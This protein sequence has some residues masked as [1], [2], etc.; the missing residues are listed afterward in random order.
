MPRLIVPT[1]APGTVDNWSLSASASSSW[2]AVRYG[3]GDD[4][5]IYTATAGITS[6]FYCGSGWAPVG[7]R[8]TA[9]TLHYRMRV[10]AATTA[11][12]NAIITQNSVQH[13]VGA[14]VVLTN[15]TWQDGEIRVREDWT[16]GVR[17]TLAEVGALG[18]GLSMAVAPGAGNI[19]VSQ[20]WLEVEYIDSMSCYDP[21]DGALPDAI[22]GP[23]NWI[24]LGTAPTVISPDNYLVITD[25]STTASKAYIHALP[26]MSQ[27]FTPEYISE[28]E[29]RFTLT[30]L[31][32]TPD[33]YLA[34]IFI[35]LGSRASVAVG[36]AKIGGNYY[37]TYTDPNFSSFPPTYTKTEMFPYNGEDVH[38]RIVTDRDSTPETYGHTQVFVNYSET[39]LLDIETAELVKMVVVAPLFLVNTNTFS[40]AVFAIDYMAW[41]HYKKRGNTFRH[42]ND[43]NFGDNVVSSESADTEI[44]RKI[45]I[46]PPGV[47]AGQSRNACVLDV[48]DPPALC[49]IFQHEQLL[50]SAPTTYKIDI[51]YKMDIA[52][53]EAELVVQRSSDLWY[54]DEAGS[55]WQSTFQAV[56][57]PNQ[58]TRTRLAAMTGINVVSVD[59]DEIIV[60][61]RRKTAVL[62]AYKILIYRVHLV[63]E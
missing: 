9:V 3:S 32:T 31:S 44:V 1:S 33:S 15:T 46:S 56:T 21:F 45:T 39:P 8:I 12:V 23:L 2:E 17:F 19:E 51:D 14:P 25:A 50:E 10:S 35:I 36:A 61:V 48:L 42:W 37:L 60:T 22:V 57:M 40:E 4:S 6:D 7:G 26:D 62:P 13:V 30:D 63:K 47:T 49:E 5:F 18:A 59:D 53:T 55:T 52:A 54:W 16:S 43:W 41:R 34:T 28:V 20:L 38:L 58:L 27:Q 11:N 24:T 29:T